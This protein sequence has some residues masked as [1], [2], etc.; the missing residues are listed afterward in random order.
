MRPPPTPDIE[1]LVP[2][3]GRM[4]LVDTIVS[5]EPGRAVTRATVASHW[6]LYAAGRVGSLVLIELVAQ[7]AAVS[8]GMDRLASGDP[9]GDKFG[10]L[11]GIGEARFFIDA[12]VPGDTVVTRVRDGFV[13][14]AYREIIGTAHLGRRLAAEVTLQVL[15][16]AGGKERLP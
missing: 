15:Q 5:A 10:Y 16:A 4:L 2:H 9:P 3:R 13:M 14:E 1:A 8:F 11:V 12:L 7:S 6:P